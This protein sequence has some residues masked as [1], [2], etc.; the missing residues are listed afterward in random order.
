GKSVTSNLSERGEP[1]SAVGAQ[2]R[3]GLKAY[4]GGL[5]KGS[6]AAVEGARRKPVPGK[7]E[8]QGGDVPPHIA[9]PHVTRP[10]RMAPEAPELSPHARAGD[11][12]LRQACPALDPHHSRARG[13]P[14]D[15]VDGAAVERPAGERHLQGGHA[16]AAGCARA[17]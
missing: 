9:G 5:D 4:Y 3:Q 2:V 10:E 14:H 11:A 6:I 17:G 8:L 15:P 12:V 1:S 7:T 13:R 16:G